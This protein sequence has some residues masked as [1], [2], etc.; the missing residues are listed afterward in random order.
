MQMTQKQKDALRQLKF[1]V[2]EWF[3]KAVPIAIVALLAWVLLTVTGTQKEIILIQADIAATRLKI[4][5]V[6]EGLIN[7]IEHHDEDSK[8]SHAQSAIIHHVDGTQRCNRC[9]E[10]VQ[11]VSSSVKK[12]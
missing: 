4:A 6:E 8:N 2:F 10:R 9:H 7:R 5:Q 11:A 1:D 3:N 12:K